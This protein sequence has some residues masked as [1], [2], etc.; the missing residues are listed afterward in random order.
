MPKKPIQKHHTKVTRSLSTSNDAQRQL[1]AW[2]H[3]GTLECIQR[4]Q[5]F[6][7]REHSSDLKG[8]AEVALQEGNYMYYDPANEKEEQDF[9]LAKMITE[10]ESVLI[11]KQMRMKTL[12]FRLKKLDIEKRVHQ[13]LIGAASKAQ[14]EDWKYNF[15]EDFYSLQKDELMEL[16]EEIV[17]SEA[18]IASAKKLITTKKYQTIPR[19][20]LMSIHLDDEEWL[21]DDC[22]GTGCGDGCCDEEVKVEDIPF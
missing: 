15:S 2:A 21:V 12:Q 20:V 7:K 6:I 14:Q 19:S 4:I 18:W 17:Y 16:G 3:E 10:R 13:K 11:D 9:L 8:F 22:A 5:D 1:T